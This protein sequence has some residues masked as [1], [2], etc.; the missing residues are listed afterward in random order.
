[1][2]THGGETTEI[3]VSFGFCP[4]WSR[5]SYGGGATSLLGSDFALGKRLPLS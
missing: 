3:S 1:M 4:T 5:S 2:G